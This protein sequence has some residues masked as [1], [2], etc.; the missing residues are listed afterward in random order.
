[1]PEGGLCL[2]QVAVSFGQLLEDQGAPF[3]APGWSAADPQAH[4]R[5]IVRASL[6]YR[7]H[8]TRDLIACHVGL[9]P[10]IIPGNVTRQRLC[11]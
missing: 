6:F 2:D 10:M 4:R 1:M 5:L 11:V 8:A 3:F 7:Q 9:M